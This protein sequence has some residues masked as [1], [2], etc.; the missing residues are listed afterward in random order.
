MV[1]T[2]AEVKLLDVKGDARERGEAHGEAMRGE[3]VSG[4]E[5]WREAL[6]IIQPLTP[7]DFIRHI[8]ATTQF[9]E[10][11]E[12]QSPDLLVEVRGIA[13]GA[14]LEFETV[15]AFQLLD[16][17]WWLSAHL[18]QQTSARQS[19]SSLA[20]CDVNGDPLVA[21]T[22]DLPLHYDGG[23]L[24]LRFTDPVTGVRQIVFTAAGLIGLN[25]LNDSRWGVCVNT[26]SELACSRSG[27]PVAFV[28]RTLLNKRDLGDAVRFVE[29]TQHAS[30]QNYVVASPEGIVDIEAGADSAIH[31]PAKGGDECVFHTNHVLVGPL[32]QD[33]PMPSTTTS[34]RFTALQCFFDQH[35]HPELGDIKSLLS[36]TDGPICVLRDSGHG[37]T[38]GACIMTLGDKPALHVAH[39][40]P[41]VM[42][43]VQHGLVTS[44]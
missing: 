42:S 25:G 17:C 29:T 16:E 1:D 31:Y 14:N 40:P 5:R 13:A 41:S 10:A 8:G 21:Q 24:L 44:E 3:I 12:Q 30:G 23:Q 7:D 39:G 11:A 9:V 35:S 28:V 6:A 43:F 33:D 4:I 37:H 18:A 38:F 2:L 32:V 27:L 34:S 20:L 26:L 15:F 22:M 36:S 19:C